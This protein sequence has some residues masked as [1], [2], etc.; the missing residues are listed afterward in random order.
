MSHTLFCVSSQRQTGSPPS[1]GG[2][3]AH[4]AT[5]HAGPPS[6]Q[7]RT[8]TRAMHRTAPH[9]TSV[10]TSRLRAI[11]C[12]KWLVAAVL[13]AGVSRQRS[14]TLEATA[15]ERERPSLGEEAT[16][17]MARS[18]PAAPC[19]A[20]DRPTAPGWAVPV[21]AQACVWSDGPVLEC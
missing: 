20:R 5:T 17:V 7:P 3:I 8:M 21:G 1:A 2:L 9:S 12:R 4:G 10:H 15:R 14:R 16:L 6:Q 13:R 19:E 18:P 11:G